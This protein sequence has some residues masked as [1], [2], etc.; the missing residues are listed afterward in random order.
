MTA[1]IVLYARRTRLPLAALTTAVP[2]NPPSLDPSVMVRLS[3][4]VA[5]AQTLGSTG[6]PT[7]PSPGKPRTLTISAGDLAIAA[8]E[9]EFDDP[10]EVFGWQVVITTGPDGTTHY[11]LDQLAVPSV[12]ADLDTVTKKLKLEVPQ[13][14]SN[15][16]LKFDVYEADGQVGSGTLT[17]PSNNP[18][19]AT[20]SVSVPGKSPPVVLVEGYPLALA[21]ASG[22]EPA[23]P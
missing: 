18:N 23:W 20:I 4:P 15:L 13:L 19:P 16:Q 5:A 9:A 2:G 6:S 12:A 11:R 10:F 1:L 8:V 22:I 17:F 21:L 14:G 7:T 3:P